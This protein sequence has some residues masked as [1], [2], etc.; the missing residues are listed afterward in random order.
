MHGG[1]TM[2]RSGDAIQLLPRAAWRN[3]NRVA[4]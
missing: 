2:A 1:V 3:S 4:F